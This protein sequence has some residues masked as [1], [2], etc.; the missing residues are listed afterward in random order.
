M[1]RLELDGLANETGRGAT[2]PDQVIK[3]VLGLASAALVQNR[4]RG[5]GKVEAAGDGA[6]VR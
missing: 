6:G 3:H 5:E 1:I 2:T 4:A